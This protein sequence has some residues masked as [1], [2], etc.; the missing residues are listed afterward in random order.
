MLI[1]IKKVARNLM[2]YNFK[3]VDLQFS[4]NKK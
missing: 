1:P 4:K 2:K 3:K